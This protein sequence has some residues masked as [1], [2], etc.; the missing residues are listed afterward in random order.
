MIKYDCFNIVTMVMLSD[1]GFVM[2]RPCIRDMFL[3]NAL[4]NNVFL[5]RQWIKCSSLFSWDIIILG[6]YV[7]VESNDMMFQ[8]YTFVYS[9]IEYI[10]RYHIANE[11]MCY[12]I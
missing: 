3:H 10:V 11:E 6:G 2:M 1:V 5:W 7:G 4:Y 9:F 8:C 12:F